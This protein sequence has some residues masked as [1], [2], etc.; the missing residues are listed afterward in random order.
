MAD[1]TAPDANLNT[2]EGGA[3]ESD[4]PVVAVH[5]TSERAAWYAALGV[6]AFATTLRLIVGARLPLLPDETY[7]WDWSR[8]LAFGYFD[9]P[10]L[11]AWMIAFGTNLL[12]DN[13][14]GVRI[15]TILA[16]TV[17]ALMMTLIARRIS[18]AH[19]AA[20]TAIVLSVMPLASAGLVLA[21]NDAPLL[22]FIALALYCIIRAVQA[23]RRSG[24][25]FRAWCWAGVALGLAFWSKYT[26]I[27][28]PVG[29]L[30]A[31]VSH[32][33]LRP[34][35]NEWG[36]YAACAIATL[37]FLPVL[38]WNARHDWISMAYQIEHGLG[39]A[40]T[41][42]GAW[43]H[44]GDLLGGQAG[45]ATPILFV[46]IAIAV[47][48]SLRPSLGPEKWLLAVVTTV[49]FAFFVYSALKKRVEANWP[50]PAYVGGVVLFAAYKWNE[51]SKRWRA[52]GIAL[53]GVLSL[54]VYLHAVKP[55]IPIPPRK[56]PVGRAF[57]W[58]EVAAAVQQA[59]RAPLPPSA[60]VF[61]AADRY[62]E[63]S[64]IAFWLDSHP[65]T[66]ALNLGGRRNQYD[67][68]PSFTDR[69]HPGDRLVVALDETE[70]VHETIAALD[71]HFASIL[72]GE[73]VEM[74]RGNGVIGLRR[75]YTLDG[76]RGTWP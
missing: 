36:P 42:R 47:A 26:S 74:Q 52:A 70:G 73:L 22:A 21:T 53:A 38:M 62:Q 59:S 39:E 24:E 34:R 18:G 6:I 43:R 68:W 7:Y 67:L 64:Q 72:R 35:F 33:S 69:A 60:R 25:S 44:E 9:H 58:R 66:F 57:G 14:L 17:A 27:L 3:S 37:I 49:F 51:V 50:A 10:P 32:R 1:S 20:E 8:H 61:L 29:A 30:L 45:L 13:P 16:G 31:F 4:A 5:A 11:I 48:R 46:M 76:W 71:P 2:S 65:E 55:I 12:G 28:L 23:E 75:I 41:L 63:A 54:A 15:M 56:D 19:T 40:I